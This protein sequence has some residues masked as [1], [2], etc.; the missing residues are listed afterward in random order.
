MMMDA[1]EPCD[2]ICSVITD[3][4]YNYSNVNFLLLPLLTEQTVP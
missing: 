2:G 4:M 3:F 1:I